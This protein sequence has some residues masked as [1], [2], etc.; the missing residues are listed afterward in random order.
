MHGTSNVKLRVSCPAVQL[1]YPGL[2]CRI[3]GVQRS[4]TD[5]QTDTYIHTC[6]NA[7]IHTYT[8]THTYIHTHT[9]TYIHTHT[10]RHKSSVVKL[11]AHY[12]II[13]FISSFQ[14]L[15]EANMKNSRDLRS[16]GLLHS[17][18]WQYLT[19]VSGRPTGPVFKD[20]ES[21][22]AVL[23]HFAAEV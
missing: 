1:P 23:M 9:H 19:D 16:S 15:K 6:M 2:C 14:V 22:N 11:K 10:H 8:H 5:R 21:K 12:T 18:Q 20:P 3:V 17:E 7:Y 13:P 4:Q